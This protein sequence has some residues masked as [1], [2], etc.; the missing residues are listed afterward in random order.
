ML[1]QVKWRKE[2]SPDNVLDSISR[3]HLTLTHSQVIQ[4][5]VVVNVGLDFLFDGQRI[6]QEY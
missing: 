6:L 4:L 1:M 2:S 3:W 5:N